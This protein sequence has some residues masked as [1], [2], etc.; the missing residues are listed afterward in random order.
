MS[1]PKT[2]QPHARITGSPGSAPAGTVTAQLVELALPA[3]TVL[4]DITREVNAF[5]QNPALYYAY[6][7]NP[8]LSLRPKTLADVNNYLTARGL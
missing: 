6:L 7:I 1:V 4:T 8:D 5:V 2:A 3:A